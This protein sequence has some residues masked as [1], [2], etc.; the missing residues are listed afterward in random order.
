[1]AKEYSYDSTYNRLYAKGGTEID[2]IT[3]SDLY[4]ADQSNGWGV[5]HKYT[6]DVY[7]LD[8]IL[9]LGDGI[10]ST[11][12]IDSRKAV[13]F[14]EYVSNPYGT[15]YVVIIEDNAHFQLGKCLD[16][17]AKAT[18]DGCQIIFNT[19]PYG[20]GFSGGSKT[21]SYFRFYG[22]SIVT[23][24]NNNKKCF[25]GVGDNTRIWNCIL[26]NYGFIVV[27][28]DGDIYNLTISGGTPK[29]NAI[30]A[31]SG[32]P[33]LDRLSFTG[34]NIVLIKQNYS[35]ENLKISNV[36][37]DCERAV[38]IG[39]SNTEGIVSMVDCELSNWKTW[40]QGEANPAK[41]L[42]KYKVNIHVADKDGNNLEGATV[43]CKDKNG[44]EVFSVQTDE[45]G[46]IE[47]QEVVFQEWYQLSY[48]EHGEEDATCYSPH[49]FEISKE[50]KETL[51]VDKITMDEKIDWHLE[52]QE[53]SAVS[54]PIL[55]GQNLSGVLEKSV[56]M[57]GTLEKEEMKG[58]LEKGEM[59]GQMEKDSMAGKLEK[60]SN[61]I[62]GEI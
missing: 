32:S 39:G 27:V 46:N 33:S 43:V 21:N 62:K 47:E 54:G 41:I 14:T 12:F 20:I 58:S 44:D 61:L 30:E 50:G 23:P 45:N 2:P 18:Y 35:K 48:G 16:E 8:C 5:V 29:V 25:I 26:E 60:D 36:K 3:F 56:E 1:M 34:V 42:R 28:G 4:N 6:T 57:K 53:P 11:Y 59:T 49:S 15:A 52:L 10:T 13:I 51:V 7:A 19:D 31:S 37:A 22:C 55:R 9:W 40:M 17:E 38:N 24:H